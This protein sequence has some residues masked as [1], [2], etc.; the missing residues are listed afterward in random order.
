VVVDSAHWNYCFLLLFGTADAVDRVRGI[1][2]QRAR[3]VVSNGCLLD[4]GSFKGF[5]PPGVT[6]RLES[7]AWACGLQSDCTERHQGLTH[8][9]LLGQRP[10]G[11][12]VQDLKHFVPECAAC[13]HFCSRYT[14]VFGVAPSVCSDMLAIFDCDL[15]DPLTHAVHTL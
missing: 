5:K 2:I 3:T 15:Q 10:G 8:V 9:V 4:V 13:G 6:A 12:C 1:G 11:A 14:D 7:W